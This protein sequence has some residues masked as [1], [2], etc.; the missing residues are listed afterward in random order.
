MVKT[1]VKQTVPLQPMEGDGGAEI[2]LQPMEDPT[3]EQVEAPEG[4]CDPMGSPP[5]SRS[6]WQDMSTCGE[7]S[8]RHS[9]FVDRT[10]DPMRDPHWSSLLLDVCTL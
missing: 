5:W 10:R 1:I 3:P 8:P 2:P 6:S 4:G 7:K 9:R